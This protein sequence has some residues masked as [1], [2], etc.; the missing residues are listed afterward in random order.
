M[1]NLDL[2]IAQAN[3]LRPLPG[4]TTELA[5]LAADPGCDLADVAKVVAYDQVLTMKLLR[6]ANSAASASAEPI[7]NVHDAVVRMGS[8]Q[9][10]SFA[11]AAAA[12]PFLQSAVPGYDLPEGALWRHSVASAVAIESLRAARIAV[13]RD[14]F[15]AALLH[16]IGKLV[17][18]RFLNPEIVGYLHEAEIGGQLSRTVAELQLLNVQHAELGGVIAQHWRLPEHVVAGIAYHHNPEQSPEPMAAVTWLANQLAKHVEAGLDSRVHTPEWNPAVTEQLGVDA[19][20][21]ADLGARADA[22]YQAV[23]PA[24]LSI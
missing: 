9:V 22:R 23:A 4:V 16:D 10:L 8:A 15:T 5:S 7:G 11:V 20:Q 19:S 14:A 1:I 2:L 13:P 3:A 6:A 17:L 24:Y 12:R 21:F 18:G